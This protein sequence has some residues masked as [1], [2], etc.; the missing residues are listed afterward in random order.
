M[1]TRGSPLQEREDNNSAWTHSVPM[2]V[3]IWLQ[4]ESDGR[5]RAYHDYC[6]GHGQIGVRERVARG[7][8]YRSTYLTSERQTRGKEPMS[9]F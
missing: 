3:R 2:Q 1:R 8:I 9:T 7:R 4:E 6:Q 5:I